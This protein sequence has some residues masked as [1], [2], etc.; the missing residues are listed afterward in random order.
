MSFFSNMEEK[1]TTADN[2]YA[3]DAIIRSHLTEF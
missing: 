3:R 1:V 2:G